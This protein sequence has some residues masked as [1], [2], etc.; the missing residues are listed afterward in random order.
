[1]KMK[2][3]LLSLFALLSLNLNAKNGFDKNIKFVKNKNKVEKKIIACLHEYYVTTIGCDGYCSTTLLAS[4]TGDCGSGQNGS[5]IK[6]NTDIDT[7]DEE[8]RDRFVRNL[9]KV[10]T[11][12][13]LS[14]W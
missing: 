2:F 6:H 5:V 4:G 3:F 1:M 13:V 12:L 14:V 11:E 9:I 8:A 10:A 7:C